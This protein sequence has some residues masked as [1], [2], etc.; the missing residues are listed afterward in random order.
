[1]KANRPALSGVANRQKINWPVENKST[2]QT[3]AAGKLR[4]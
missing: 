4:T 2:G 3:T 1:M